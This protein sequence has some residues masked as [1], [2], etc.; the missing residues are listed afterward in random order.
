MSTGRSDSIAAACVACWML[1][2]CTQPVLAAASSTTIDTSAYL[3]NSE[4]ETLLTQLT[5][6]YPHLVT[7]DSLG[8]SVQGEEL[9]F[10]T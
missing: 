8:K 5:N 3:N 2:A 4:L 6:N 1:L 10:V 7:L 9:W